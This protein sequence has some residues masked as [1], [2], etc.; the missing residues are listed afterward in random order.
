MRV[1][2]ISVNSPILP[3]KTTKL[4]NTEFATK[5]TKGGASVPASRSPWRGEAERRRLNPKP[6]TF[7][8]FFGYWI[9]EISTRAPKSGPSAS[10]WGAVSDW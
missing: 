7:P 9:L 10:R 4:L 3:T 2:S 5:S 1:G 8:E 6:S